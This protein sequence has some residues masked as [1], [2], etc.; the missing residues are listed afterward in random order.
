MKKYISL[1]V[2]LLLAL[3]VGSAPAQSAD[4]NVTIRV[5]D[6]FGNPVSNG[7]SQVS[8]NFSSETFP[9]VGGSVSLLLPDGKHDI[10]LRT[11]P[12][13]TNGNITSH[14][15][16]FTI[17]LKGKSDV[18]VQ[19]PEVI[20]FAFDV[21]SPRNGFVEFGVR[22]FKKSFPPSALGGVPATNA[23]AKVT[24]GQSQSEVRGYPG[25]LALQFDSSFGYG[26]DA[27]PMFRSRLGLRVVDGVIRF[28]TFAPL[29][30]VQAPAEGVVQS[31]G[32]SDFDGDGYGDYTYGY[33]LGANSSKTVDVSY[34]QIR[35]G[36]VSAPLE[37]LTDIQIEPV[38]TTISGAQF[39][40]KGRVVASSPAYIPVS[41]PVTIVAWKKSTNSTGGISPL[42]VT[43]GNAKLESD[44]SFT[45][46]ASLQPRWMVDLYTMAFVINSP[47]GISSQVFS[48][49]E[50]VKKYKS[51]TYMNMDYPGGIA[52]ST[53]SKNKGAKTKQKPTVS[54]ATYNLN[55]VLDT[56][57]D[58]LAC[59][60]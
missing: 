8:T 51:C 27:S 12:P 39:V 42:E 40:V 34:K 5:I 41:S 47:G 32:E 36:V 13:A 10:S 3:T 33:K 57:K 54:A 6:N 14:N 31:P 59:E 50:I 23:K 28:K 26:L 20:E 44:G 38:A 49:P 35:A 25:Q 16:Y 15:F 9:V 2:A 24:I 60:R 21:G 52:K 53:G 37:G 18:V 43:I 22:S 7:L 29:P 58:G 17:D 1:I 56:D 30:L 55:K 19:L 11:S 45:L 48:L 46:R 4:P